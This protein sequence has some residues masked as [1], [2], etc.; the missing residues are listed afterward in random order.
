[1]P[2]IVLP[3][4]TYIPPGGGDSAGAPPVS[5]QPPPR[6]RGR[7]PARPAVEE[8]PDGPDRE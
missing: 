5:D 7:K 2:R 4:R 8:K 1:M 6:K 3:R